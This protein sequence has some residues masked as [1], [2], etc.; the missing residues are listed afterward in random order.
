MQG[1]LWTETVRTAD[2]MYSMIF[3]RM[4]A[5]A[6]RAWHRASWEDITVKKDKDAKRAADW[7][8][9]ANALGYKEL[10][11]LDKMGVPYRLPPPGAR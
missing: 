1:H 3:P 8:Q 11:R 6:E 9:F 5:L 10:E 7:V 4:I 2:Q